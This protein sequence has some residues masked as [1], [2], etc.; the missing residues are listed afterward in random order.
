MSAL[1]MVCGITCLAMVLIVKF[2]PI[3]LVLALAAFP[4]QVKPA[5]VFTD[6]GSG[7]HNGHSDFRSFS[8]FT[9]IL[10]TGHYFQ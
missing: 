8:L 1:V 4:Q 2:F 10:F 7:A 9:E 6:T 3:W 5:A